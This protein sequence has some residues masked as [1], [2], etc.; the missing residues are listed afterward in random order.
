MKKQ[1][2]KYS[3]YLNGKNNYVEVPYS[4]L[5]YPW[6]DN[7]PCTFEVLVKPDFEGPQDTPKIVLQYRDDV[8]T[9]RSIV[10]ADTNGYWASYF[11]GSTLESTVAVDKGKYTLIH[12]R[13]DSSVLK[14][15][16]NTEPDAEDKR[17]V[18]EGKVGNLLIGMHKQNTY[19]FNG[20]IVFVRIYN[21]ALS[22]SEI[23]HNFENPY[24]PV[25]DGLVL[26]LLMDEGKGDVVYDKSGNGNDGTIY[27]AE[28]V[29]SPVLQWSPV[30]IGE[31]TVY[32]SSV[33]W[34]YEGGVRAVRFLG[35]EC[36]LV[37]AS[38]GKVEE[39]VEVEVKNK[40][41]D[42]FLSD[43]EMLKSY[44][45]EEVYVKFSYFPVYPMI[46]SSVEKREET[47]NML[48]VFIKLKPVM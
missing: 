16:I 3:L 40:V 2:T 19:F 34:S 4:D 5:L 14:F 43:I 9:G 46:V 12:L 36:G 23:K 6:K 21:R 30:K 39:E 11:G 1:M 35:A 31:V 33:K 48:S 29:R 37:Y 22:E 44:I 15:Y 27:G 25:S 18:D 8:G 28:W 42:S 26:W 32:P 45:G 20:F 7:S 41:S 47:H 38:T 13:Y 10:Y 24:M 17:G